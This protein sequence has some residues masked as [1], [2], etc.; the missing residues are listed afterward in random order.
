MAGAFYLLMRGENQMSYFSDATLAIAEIGG[1]GDHTLSGNEF[2]RDDRRMR[3]KIASGCLCDWVH[4][5]LI[6]NSGDAPYGMGIFK[7]EHL[8]IIARMIATGM[9]AQHD[10]DLEMQG[11]IVSTLAD[12]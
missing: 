9:M 10:L 7:Q 11:E 2:D 3:I 6:E 1:H 5:Y 8:P 4:E 12:S